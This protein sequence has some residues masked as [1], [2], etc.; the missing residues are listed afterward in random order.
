[1]DSNGGHDFDFELTVSGQ[2]P[3]GKNAVIVTRAGHRF[4]SARFV[5][6]RQAALNEV[7]PQMKNIE[8]KLPLTAPVNVS[9]EYIAKDRIR[10]DKP[11]IEDALWHLLEKVGVVSDDTFLGGYNCESHFFN[12]GVDKKNTGVRIRIWGNYARSVP[13]YK[14]QSKAR[15]KGKSTRFNV[16]TPRRRGKKALDESHLGSSIRT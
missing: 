8:A 10:R 6:W 5:A 16:R 1:M 13:L 11:G 12:L 15:T 2:C 14:K 9:I 3:S 7:L 4:P